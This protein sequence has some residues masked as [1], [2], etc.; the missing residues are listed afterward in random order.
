M[1]LAR[2]AEYVTSV[3]TIFRH[4]TQSRNLEIFSAFHT[5]SNFDILWSTLSWFLICRQNYSL[6]LF[7]SLINFSSVQKKLGN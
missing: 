2:S 1:M 6:L 5:N 4:Y 3:I 7:I